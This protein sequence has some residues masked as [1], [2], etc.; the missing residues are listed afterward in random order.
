MGI[1]FSKP[2]HVARQAREQ[3]LTKPIHKMDESL[4][5][6]IHKNAILR[7]KEKHFANE[8][9]NLTNLIRDLDKK[10]AECNEKVDDLAFKDVDEHLEVHDRLGG[11]SRKHRNYKNR[12]HKKLRKRNVH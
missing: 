2:K 6:D 9:R 8:R 12:T 1:N 5:E 10:L 3:T 4:K 7:D 11:K